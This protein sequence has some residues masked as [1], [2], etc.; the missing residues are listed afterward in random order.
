MTGNLKDLRRA[1][2]LAV[3]AAIAEDGDPLGEALPQQSAGGLGPPKYFLLSLCPRPVSAPL[4]NAIRLQS[5]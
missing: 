3:P 1:T 4:I 5:G 2:E